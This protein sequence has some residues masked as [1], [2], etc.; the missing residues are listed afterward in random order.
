MRLLSRVSTH[1]TN[2]E[3]LETQGRK[4]IM[5]LGP[6]HSWD[7]ESE[8]KR[9]TC[10]AEVKKNA[11]DFVGEVGQTAVWSKADPSKPGLSTSRI[12]GYSSANECE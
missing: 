9:A 5:M 1:F 10:G 8:A 6:D 3:P 11:I 4:H 7:N 12:L 2:P